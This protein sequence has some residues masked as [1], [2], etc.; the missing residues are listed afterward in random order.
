MFFT[1]EIKIVFLSSVM[2]LGLFSLLVNNIN[3]VNIQNSINSDFN[4]QKKQTQKKLD[5]LLTTQQGEIAK[6]IDKNINEKKIETV[7][8]GSK[9]KQSDI[10]ILVNIDRQNPKN[11]SP[12]LNSPVLMNR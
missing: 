12:K 1:K 8:A 2:I 6:I 10:D 9:L 4:L 11:S 3:Q 5:G 7:F